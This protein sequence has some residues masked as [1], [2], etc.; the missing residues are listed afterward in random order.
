MSQL[1]SSDD[2]AS[3]SPGKSGSFL[4]VRNVLLESLQ[5][6]PVFSGLNKFVRPLGEILIRSS[7]RVDLEERLIDVGV[8][9]QNLVFLS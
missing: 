6:A 9:S 3:V 8:L 1:S 7:L 2:L 4:N 5:E